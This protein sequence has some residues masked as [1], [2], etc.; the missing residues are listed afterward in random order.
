MQMST[1]TVTQGM[2]LSDKK[3]KVTKTE[4]KIRPNVLLIFSPRFLPETDSSSPSTS[5][6]SCFCYRLSFC[7]LSSID[8]NAAC[9]SG[10]FHSF[11]SPFHAG[12]C[13][14]L[15]ILC[16]SKSL[17][18][19]GAVSLTFTSFFFLSFSFQEKTLMKLY[20]VTKTAI[21]M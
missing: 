12:L 11:C 16:F 17:P 4:G 21:E 7:R 1:P 3:E 14:F 20:D 15:P 9:E 19:E 13:L 10:L 2:R 5:L 18:Q 6:H 8:S